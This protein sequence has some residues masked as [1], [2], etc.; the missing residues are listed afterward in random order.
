MTPRVSCPG[1]EHP[2]YLVE[3]RPRYLS[4]ILCAIYFAVQNGARVINMSFSFSTYS[5]EVACALKDAH[6]PS[7]DLCGFGR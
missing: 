2:M 3:V 1:D 7:S 4:D 6:L 5:H